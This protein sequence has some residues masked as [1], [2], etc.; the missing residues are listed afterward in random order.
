MT[1]SRG[2][3]RGAPGLTPGSGYNFDLMFCV[4]SAGT[5]AVYVNDQTGTTPQL[6][7]SGTGAPVVMT[8]QAV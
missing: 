2:R 4:N 6:A 1:C 3:P 7:N 5:L 8:V